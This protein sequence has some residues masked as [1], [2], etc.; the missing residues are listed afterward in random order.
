VREKGGG[1]KINLWRKKE[2]IQSDRRGKNDKNRKTKWDGMKEREREYGEGE[3]EL[4]RKERDVDELK[5][6]GW[7]EEVER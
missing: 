2:L 3:R 7:K 4:G 6:R 1:R 5:G